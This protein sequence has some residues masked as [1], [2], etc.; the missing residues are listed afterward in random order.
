MQVGAGWQH[1][2]GEPVAVGAL[3]VGAGRRQ[4]DAQRRLARVAGGETEV[5]QQEGLHGR[6]RPHRTREQQRGE[7]AAGRE[8]AR[9]RPRVEQALQRQGLHGGGGVAQQLLDHRP[10]LVAQLAVGQVVQL[11]GG[12]EALVQF[13]E[14]AFEPDRQV[15][16]TEGPAQRVAQEAH[17]AAD[18][19]GQH[20]RG[21][22][23]RRI[24]AGSRSHR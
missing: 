8:G 23:A 14:G 9:R 24:G 11:H 15:D 6:R 3:Q 21:V 1:D 20:H 7:P 18:Q 13:G 10:R 5:A 22:E 17:G 19:Q 2:L 4:L 12:H 16:L